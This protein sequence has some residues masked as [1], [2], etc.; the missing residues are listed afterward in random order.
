MWYVDSGCS[1]H[2]TGNR[3]LLSNIK[4]CERGD[5][6]F[7]DNQKGRVIGIGNVSSKYDNFIKNVMLVDNLKYNLISVS[8]L[9]DKN[10]DVKFEKNA[11]HI[12]NPFNNCVIFSSK[13]FKDTYL[14]NVDDMKCES[15]VC[16]N[17]VNNNNWL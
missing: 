10:V 9:C 12:I 8:Q 17:V 15:N 6:T 2:M 1:R 4:E 14:L 11:W 3:K 5:V 16:L 7:G 13:R